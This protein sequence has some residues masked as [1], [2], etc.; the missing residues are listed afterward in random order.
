MSSKRRTAA[1]EPFLVVR[2]AASD[3][4]ADEGVAPHAHDWHQ[5]IHATHGVL[6]VWTER[7]SWVAPPSWAIWVPAGVRHG[8]RFAGAVAFRTLYLRPE[9]T[10]GLPDDCTAVAVSPLLR[11]LILRA[12]AARMLDRRDPAEAAVALLIQDEFR[13]AGAPPFDLP[14]P[15]S[16]AMRRAAELAR[17]P[18]ALATPEIARAAG[19]SVRALERRFRA[20]TGMSLGRWRRHALLLA[21]MEGLAG[22]MSVKRVAADAG[23]ATP[24]AFV[25]AFRA[26]FGETPG[27]YFVRG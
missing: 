9:A 1:D 27:R 16:P 10:A 26:V 21:A 18:G 23:Y 19:T 13:R 4:R 8:I 6:S 7:G 24:S 14:Q 12:V 2:T 15:A 17:G 5:L 22:G 11:E 20:E 3:H 25:A